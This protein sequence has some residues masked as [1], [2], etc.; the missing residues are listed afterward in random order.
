M[1]WAL[2]AAKNDG[3]ALTDVAV[4]GDFLVKLRA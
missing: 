3:K 2:P 1:G 4:D